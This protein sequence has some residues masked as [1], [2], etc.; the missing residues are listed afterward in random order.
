MRFEYLGIEITGYGDIEAEVRIQAAKAARA[1]AYLNDIIFRNKYI[2]IE[3]KSRI[4][5]AV[6]RPILT[7]TAETRPDTSKTKGILETTEMKILRRIVGKTIC[8]RKRSE[9]V[10]KTCKFDNVNE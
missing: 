5:K 7:Y 8:D 4:H 6:I 10:R 1:S 9:D 2:G 3:I